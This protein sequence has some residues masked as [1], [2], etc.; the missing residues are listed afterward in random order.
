M[1][2][3]MLDRKYFEEILPDQLRL[4]E[5]P[6]RLTVH[7]TTGDEYAVH[8]LVATH[9]AYVIF[10]V[11]DKGKEPKHSKAWREA[12]PTHYAAI[13]DQV[14][15]PYSGIAVAHLTARTTKGDDARLLVAFQAK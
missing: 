10:K 1:F 3:P 8:S 14:S 15:I 7:L 2:G 5:R 9:D 12:N 11:Y 13:F 6:V 4:M